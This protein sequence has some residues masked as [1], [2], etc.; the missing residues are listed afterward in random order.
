M[1][2]VP[3]NKSLK[4]VQ[5]SLIFC[6]AMQILFWRKT[7][8]IKPKLGLIP[9]LPNRYTIKAL[10][11]GEEEFFFRTQAYKIQNAGDTFG[12]F[13]ALK[14]Y[15]YEKLYQ[16]FKLLDTLNFKSNYVPSLAAYYYSQTQNKPD[17]KYII[18]YLEERADQDPENNWWWYYQATNL[19][20]YVLKDKDR[21]LKIA[22]KLKNIESDIPFG[23]KELVAVL[24][25]E[26]G[27]DCEAI[28][29]IQE[30]AKDYE[31]E[32]RKL[33]DKELDFI[34]YF[35]QKR[36]ESLKAKNFDASECLGDR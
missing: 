11:F 24:H 16:W 10:S 33:S 12:R 4:I 28:M 22:Y 29:L 15:D 2:T 26:R 9:N 6:L 21:A 35:I 30:I 36:L 8:N 34:K 13:S 23:A 31:S 19:A 7:E 17:T 32:N 27:E 18:D 25:K 5:F 1:R 20:T 14:D 3:K